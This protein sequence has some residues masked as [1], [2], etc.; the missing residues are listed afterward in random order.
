MAPSTCFTA[1]VRALVLGKDLTNNRSTRVHVDVL[2]SV[3]VYLQIMATGSVEK[4][5]VASVHVYVVLLFSS[6]PSSPL[7]LLFLERFCI[8][9]RS[10]S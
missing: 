10:T 2:T 4:A 8:Y 9:P 1:H 6:S 7:A 5:S 3:H